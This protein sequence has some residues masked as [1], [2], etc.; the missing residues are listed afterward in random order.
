MINIHIED[1]KTFTKKLFIGNDFDE[2]LLVE[3]C[4]ITDNTYNIDG[5]IQK[6]F[7]TKEEYEILEEKEFSKWAKIKKLCFE[8][9]KGTKL[10][11]KFKIVLKLPKRYVES[12][13]GRVETSFMSEDIL[14]LAINIKY[15]N[16]SMDIVTATSLKLFSMDKTVEDEFD[17][18]VSKELL[19]LD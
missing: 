17:K 8:M 15:E 14:G 9:I 13:L 2:L 3:A 5:R 12:I 18:Y 11:L 19:A 6:K 4:I 16:D 10:P 1:K 7:Y